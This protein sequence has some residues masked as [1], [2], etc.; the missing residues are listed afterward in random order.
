MSLVLASEEATALAGCLLDD[1]L[2]Q[3]PWHSLT[4]AV[5]MCLQHRT[6][7]LAAKVLEQAGLDP[8]VNEMM[9]RLNQEEDCMIIISADG[10]IRHTSK[11]MTKVWSCNFQTDSVLRGALA[12]SSHAETATLLCD[13]T[14]GYGKEPWV[15]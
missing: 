14:I 6:E 1:A 2:W 15:I 11:G 7:A 3:Q 5:L 8:E 4:C 10:V 9:S 12:V 13:Q